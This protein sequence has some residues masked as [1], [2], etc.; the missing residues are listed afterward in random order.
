MGGRI[1]PTLVAEP[2]SSG[3]A[4]AKL[5]VLKLPERTISPTMRF[6]LFYPVLIQVMTM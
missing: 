5:W 6:G 2:I 4:S 3:V 1:S